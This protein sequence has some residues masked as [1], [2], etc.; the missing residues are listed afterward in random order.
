M[1]TN[2]KCYRSMSVKTFSFIIFFFYSSI[3]SICMNFSMSFIHCRVIQQLKV[4]NFKNQILIDCRRIVC[5]PTCVVFRE[6]YV[7]PFGECL[8]RSSK[9]YQRKKEIFKTVCYITLK[10]RSVADYGSDRRTRFLCYCA[11][12]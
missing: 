6:I 2:Y 9:E 7:K 12:N 1:F 5:C 8:L 4:N 3:I 10:C 11:F